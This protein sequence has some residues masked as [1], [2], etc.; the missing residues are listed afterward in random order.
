MQFASYYVQA[1]LAVLLR[2]SEAGGPRHWQQAAKWALDLGVVKDLAACKV[3]S[4]DHA[5]LFDLVR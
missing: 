1:Q 5:A 3:G 4:R 2:L